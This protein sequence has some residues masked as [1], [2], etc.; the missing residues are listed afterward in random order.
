MAPLCRDQDGPSLLTFLL[1]FSKL[2]TPSPLWQPVPGLCYLHSREVLP[3]VQKQ[4]PELQF[5]PIASGPGT[6]GK[7]VSI[8]FA[9][10]LHVFRHTDKR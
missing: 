7:S 3:G 9:P 5:V 4:Y 1:S 6:T 10:F 8:I 2:E